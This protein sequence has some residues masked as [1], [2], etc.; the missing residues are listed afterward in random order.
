MQPFRELSLL[1]RRFGCNKVYCEWSTQKFWPSSAPLFDFIASYD[2]VECI[3]PSFKLV[4][5]L[6][7]FSINYKYVDKR[8]RYKANVEVS[9]SIM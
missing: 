2:I 9:D 5:K 8:C 4:Q 6:L 1:S 3:K 7:L